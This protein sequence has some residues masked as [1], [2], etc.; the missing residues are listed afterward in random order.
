MKKLLTAA[1]MLAAVLMSAPVGADIWDETTD[2]GGDAGDF[3]VGGFQTVTSSTLFDQI[4]GN[5]QD[6]GGA[7][8]V[9]AYLI[10]I[11]NADWDIEV[12]AGSETDTRLWLFDTAGNLLMF[13]DDSSQSGAALHSLLSDTAT[14]PGADGLVNSPIDPAVGDQVIVVVNG[15]AD[16]ALDANGVNLADSGNSFDGLHGINPASDG[17]FASWE[18]AVNAGGTYT[19]ALS[20]ANFGTLVAI[21]EPTSLGLLALGL[22]C[23]VVRRRRK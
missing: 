4:E 3:P 7:S 9:D 15:F 20:G 16:D 18:G 17:V 13:N 6:N 10:T 5:L 23:V 2:G 19:L 12:T 11:N 22:G 1:A 8:D 21:P 14:F